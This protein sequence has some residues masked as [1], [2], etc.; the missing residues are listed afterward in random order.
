MPITLNPLILFSWDLQMID[1]LLDL[2]P[3][4]RICDIL[5]DICEALLVVALSCIEVIIIVI[6]VTVEDVLQA[7]LN[8]VT[9]FS[10]NLG[11]FLRLLSN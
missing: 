2:R 6:I 8:L 11:Y 5:A 9:T 10:V 4:K 1:F 7:A 3:W